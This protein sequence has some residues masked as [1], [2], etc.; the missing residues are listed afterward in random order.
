MTQISEHFTLEELIR[1]DTGTRLGID[2]TPEQNYI[3]NLKL[4]CDNILEPIRAHFGVVRVNSGYRCLALNMAI[5]PMTSTVAKVSKHSYGQAADIEVDGIDNGA[6]AL[7]CAENLP[8]FEQVILE[9]YTPGQPHSGWVHVA[10]CVGEQKKE[11]LTAARINGK[12][13]Y[14]PGIHP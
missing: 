8:E 6:L 7:W 3:D 11:V 5:N 14:S 12:T 1:S 2:N 9:M 4:L 13:V 10:F